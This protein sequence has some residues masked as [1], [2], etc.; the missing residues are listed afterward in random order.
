MR[1]VVQFEGRVRLARAGYAGAEVDMV[2]CVE[3]IGL[4]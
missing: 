3:E 4:G 2:S 1:E